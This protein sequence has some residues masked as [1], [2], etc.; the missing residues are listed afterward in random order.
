MSREASPTRAARRERLL[1]SPEETEQAG[2]SLAVV[3]APGDVVALSGPLGAGK[4]R[5][6]AGIA[7]GLG[8]RSG[9]RSPTFTL[10]N[11]YRGR[12]PLFHADLYRVD[13]PDV[14]ALG[15]DE[16]LE[17]GAL[18]V[19]WGE[20]LPDRLRAPALE[21]R[22]APRSDHERMLEARATEARATA[23]LDDWSRSWPSP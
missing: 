14:P 17:S 10:I 3:L 21:I 1:A 9:V 22:L 12:L 6:V 2:E 16:A 8:V 15:L 7:R 23:L 5:L 13:E 4:T 18:V 11:E 19:E 20:K